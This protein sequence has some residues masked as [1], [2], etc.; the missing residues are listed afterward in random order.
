MFDSINTWNT[1]ESRSFRDEVAIRMVAAVMPEMYGS[2]GPW[3]KK[4]IA[5][6]FDIAEMVDEERVRRMNEAIKQTQKEISD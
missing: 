4:A 1:T 6:C 3:K 5:F 2:D